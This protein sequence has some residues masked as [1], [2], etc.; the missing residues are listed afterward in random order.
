MFR[1]RLR[2]PCQNQ[3]SADTRYALHDKTET[4]LAW[5]PTQIVQI[6]GTVIT[7]VNTDMAPSARRS[8]ASETAGCPPGPA[9]CG[10]IGS[11]FRLAFGL[12]LGL[13]LRR[14]LGGGARG[15]I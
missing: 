4:P 12:L 9:G 1:S 13:G 11:S 3:S 5:W 7:M 2:R 14:G 8:S 10:P 6:C 15:G